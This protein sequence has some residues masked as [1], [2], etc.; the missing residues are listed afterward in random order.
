MGL[1]P[2]P[3]SWVH[4]ITFLNRRE[5]WGYLLRRKWENS[6]FSKMNGLLSY[7]G[8]ASP[9]AGSRESQQSCLL[10]TNTPTFQGGLIMD[11]LFGTQGVGEESSNDPSESHESCTWEY[12]LFIHFGTKPTLINFEEKEP[13]RSWH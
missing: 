12:V 6:Q 1:L 11:K 10:P 8:T 9:D 5:Q 3:L 13:E 7:W 4:C 2:S